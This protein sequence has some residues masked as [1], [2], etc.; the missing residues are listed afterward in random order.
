MI[1]V[2]RGS[3]RAMTELSR[4]V[5]DLPTGRQGAPFELL[6][7]LE[8]PAS[9]D[10]SLL[11]IADRLREAFAVDLVLV[12]AAEEDR[13]R[14]GR[15]YSAGDPEIARTYGPALG[16][17]RPETADLGLTG[18]A[19]GRTVIWPDVM[20][21]P[22]VLARLARDRGRGGTPSRRAK[23]PGGRE[24]GG[25]AAANPE[26]P[27]PRGAR[28]RQPHRPRAH[29]RDGAAGAR[30][31][32]APDLAGGPERPPARPQPP[33]AA[34]PRGGARDH[35]QRRHRHRH[36][37]HDQRGQPRLRGAPAGAAR[38]P[39]GPAGRTDAP[40]AHQAP[41]PR[42]R[43]LRG[44]RDAACGSAPIRRCATSW[45]RST[46]WSWSASAHRCATRRARSSAES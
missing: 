5:T 31:A 30:G 20:A 23:R 19:G 22:A 2:H 34:G 8:P 7:G 17:L 15:A 10:Q 27:A 32:R 28:P 43:R 13:K 44:D 40:R 4:R 9:L 42:P 39:R 14:V 3:G 33:H 29:R 12:R 16:A 26:Q 1:D 37:R 38:P 6:A 21:E 18:L 46:A 24:R 11:L 36:R 35:P 41:V 45:R 25:H